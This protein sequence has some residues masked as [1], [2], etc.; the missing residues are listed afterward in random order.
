MGMTCRIIIYGKVTRNRLD[1]HSSS[2]ACTLEKQ[3]IHNNIV[4]IFKREFPLLLGYFSIFR[5]LKKGV[6]SAVGF[7]HCAGS[8]E[9]LFLS[10]K[11]YPHKCAEAGARTRDLPVTDGRL[12]CC[13]RPALLS[14]DL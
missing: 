5:S 2:T 14:F 7:P 9:G 10:P 3:M 4:E 12:Y 6:P 1:A 11:S 13:T 8:G